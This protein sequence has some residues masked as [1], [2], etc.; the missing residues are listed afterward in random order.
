VPPQPSTRR[1]AA[2]AVALLASFA[3][4]LTGAAAA[5][6]NTRSFHAYANHGDAFYFKLARVKPSRVKY[7]TVVVLGERWKVGERRLA[8]AIRRK[9]LR[10]RTPR[11]VHAALSRHVTTARARRSA[12]LVVHLRGRKQ[13]RNPA[14]SGGQSNPAPASGGQGQN[15]PLTGPISNDTAPCD[16]GLGSFGAGRWPSGCWRPYNDSSPFN[17]PLPANPRVIEN[18]DAVVDRLVGFGNLQNMLAGRPGTSED[19]GHPTYWSTPDDPYFTIHCTESWGRCALEGMSIQIPDK[20][21]PAGGSDGHLTVVDQR[22]GW[23]YDMWAVQSKPAGGGTLVTHW[24]GKTRIDGDGLGSDAVAAEFGTMG[25]K[26]RAEEMQ[27]GR[28][29]HA[30]F[31]FV[32]CDSGKAVFPA[33]HSGRSCS[34]IGLSNANAPSMGMRFQLDMTEEQIDALNVPEY[35]KIVL[36]A[37]ARYGMYVGDTGGTWGV[38]EESGATYSSLGYKDKWIEYAKQVGVPYYAPDDDWVFNLRDG[39]DWRRHLRVVDP[40]EANGSC[41]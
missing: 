9:K 32:N 11:R 18:S 17:R 8:R 12:K 13:K 3:L 27:A 7:A 41:S 33:G 23:E 30:L 40:C 35:R 20:A 1:I 22:T 25:G 28:I 26:I 16:A 24:G 31:M 10:A 14:S 15:P 38:K 5:S 34:S 19:Y 21:R 37:M 4:L 6:A 2:S 39:V 36:R 29:N